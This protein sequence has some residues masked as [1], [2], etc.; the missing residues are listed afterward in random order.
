M[1]CN[2]DQTYDK[3]NPEI[4][5]DNKMNKWKKHIISKYQICDLVL[6][7]TKCLSGIYLSEC[8][9]CHAFNLDPAEMFIVTA[10]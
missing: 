9:V 7:K 8:S 3:P 10:D 6:A 4:I 2:L 5:P 1:K